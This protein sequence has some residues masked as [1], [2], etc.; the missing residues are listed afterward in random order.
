MGATRNDITGDVIASKVRGASDMD[1]YQSGWDRIF[2][3]KPVDTDAG[4]NDIVDRN[5]DRD[6][7]DHD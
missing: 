6:G 7:E 4:W 1:A 5:P 3:K 2:G